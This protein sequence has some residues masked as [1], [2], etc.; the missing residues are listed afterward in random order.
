M[1]NISNHWI[2]NQNSLLKF[3]ADQHLQLLKYT[4]KILWSK[5]F[6]L[7]CLP[8]RKCYIYNNIIPYVSYD[9]RTGIQCSVQCVLCYGQ[10]MLK[11]TKTNRLMLRCDRCR[12]LLFANS[13]TSQVILR[14][15]A[16]HGGH[17]PFNYGSNNRRD[18]KT[19]SSGWSQIYWPFS[20]H[21]VLY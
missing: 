18:P 13:I 21:I 9:N 17:V 3:V 11:A 12:C 5:Y 8:H 1:I 19:V 15:L 7:Y 2:C 6:W 16:D 14:N 20:S 4:F 10:A